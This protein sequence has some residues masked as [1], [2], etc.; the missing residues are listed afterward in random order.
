[1]GAGVG[2]ALPSLAWRHSSIGA[3]NKGMRNCES[4]GFES[5]RSF[6][7]AG[8]FTASARQQSWIPN[9]NIRMNIRQV[10]K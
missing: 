6:R 2:P 9:I 5:V 7:E 10:D 4:S 1:M 3:G 8:K